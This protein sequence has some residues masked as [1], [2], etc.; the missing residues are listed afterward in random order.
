MFAA[1]LAPPRR[2]LTAPTLGNRQV[3]APGFMIWTG[4]Q[5]VLYALTG[6]V[7]TYGGQRGW[8]ARAARH[9]RT[10]RPC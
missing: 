2:C 3:N 8:A 4:G 9:A 6:S 7:A 5:R 10:Y 1:L